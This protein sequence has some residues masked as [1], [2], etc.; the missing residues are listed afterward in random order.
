MG[1]IR[2]C[3]IQFDIP[4][5]EAEGDYHEEAEDCADYERGAATIF[6][7]EEGETFF[8]EDGGGD[9]GFGGDFVNLRIGFCGEG[10]SHFLRAE[11]ADIPE[12]DIIMGGEI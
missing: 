5:E 11:A 6:L 10:N 3:I 2:A 1:D 12:I 9:I 8:V 4:E 7:H